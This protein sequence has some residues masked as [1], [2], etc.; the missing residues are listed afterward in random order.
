MSDTLRDTTIQERTGVSARRSTKRV[1][2]GTAVAHPLLYQ[3]NTRVLL[4]SIS[5][6]LGRAATLDDI[7]DD[8]LD[9]IAVQGF[10]LVWFLGV[11]ETG[12]AGR[13]V[14]LS[15]PAWRHEFATLLPDLTERD[16]CGSCFAITGYT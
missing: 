10:D 12:E 15:N 1:P 3:I 16:I 5:D 7:R 4:R 8:E 2:P 13:R 11:W 9:R 14:S 6:K